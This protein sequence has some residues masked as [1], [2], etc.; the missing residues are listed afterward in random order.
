MKKNNGGNG[1]FSYDKYQLKALKEQERVRRANANL[2]LREVWKRICMEHR[3]VRLEPLARFC[4]P[5]GWY[6]TLA[7]IPLFILERLLRFVVS[8]YTFLTVGWM[9]RLGNSIY[10]FGISKKV[11]YPDPHHMKMVIKVRGKIVEELELPV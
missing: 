4:M 3:N 8:S 5:P 10:L 6:R 7:A 11:Y 2:H 1:Q 9:I